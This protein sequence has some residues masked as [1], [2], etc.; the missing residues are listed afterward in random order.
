MERRHLLQGLAL[1]PLLVG[2]NMPRR[3][4]ARVFGDG[5]EPGL[6]DLG[7]LGWL[8]AFRVPESSNGGI[9]GDSFHYCGDPVIAM[10]SAPDRVFMVGQD[11]GGTKEIRTVA[12][13][14]VPDLVASGDLA[15]TAIAAYTQPFANLLQGLPVIPPGWDSDRVVSGLYHDRQSGRLAVNVTRY[16]DAGYPPN[17][18]TTLVLQRGDALGQTNG[19][20]GFFRMT[21]GARS[22]GWISPVPAEFRQALGC[23]HLF[24]NSDGFSILSR[25]SIGPSAFGY[26]LD[27]ITGDSP[28]ADGAAID[29]QPLIDFPITHPLTPEHLLSAPG[30]IWTV[31]SSAK[32]GFIVPGTRT[33]LAIG[34]SGGHAHGVGYGVPPWDP[35]GASGFYPVQPDDVG[36]HYWSFRVDDMIAVRQG[37]M[38]PHALRPYAHGDWV[39]PFQGERYAGRLNPVAGGCFDPD[40]GR[41]YVSLARADR[42]REGAL[43][44][45]LGFAFP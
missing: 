10:G 28:P 12:E 3:A 41:L 42:S 40:T 13:L 18:H 2:A 9:P 6:F 5:F 32:Y 25:A 11:L 24:G 37:Q 15:D 45:V 27:Q 14:Q 36:N 31:L 21:G 17:A 1:A 35:Q 44:L 19:K 20:R 34:T 30:Q 33:Y 7:E 29:A 8:G 43:P 16:Y 22:S 23:S 38:A 4:S 39:L 26:V